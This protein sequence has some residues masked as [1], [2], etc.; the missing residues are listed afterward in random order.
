MNKRN[1]QRD[2]EANIKRN[3]FMVIKT[4]SITFSL[5]FLNFSSMIYLSKEKS[6]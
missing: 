2:A 4:I 3:K 1:F 6:I 5:L